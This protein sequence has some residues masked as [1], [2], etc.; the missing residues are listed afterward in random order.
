MFLY[1]MHQYFKFFV[2]IGLMDGLLR[3]K[4]V[5]SKH[6]VVSDGVHILF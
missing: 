4:L 1:Y 6:I 3:P 5:A 2:N